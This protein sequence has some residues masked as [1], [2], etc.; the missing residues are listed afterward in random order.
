LRRLLRAFEPGFLPEFY[1][2]ASTGQ[3]TERQWW[4]FP[5]WL[6]FQQGGYLGYG[7]VPAF[8][9][10]SEP[11]EPL[12]LFLP[13]GDYRYFRQQLWFSTDPS[14]ILYLFGQIDGGTYFNGRLL[15]ADIS[16]QCSPSPYFSMVGR[17]N[18][19][20][21]R[22][23]GEPAVDATVDLFSL[24]GRLALN[25]RLQL[26]G[27]YQR[28]TGGDTWNYN[29]RLSWEFAPLSFVYLVY[30]H[31]AYQDDWRLQRREEHAIFKVSYL[32]QL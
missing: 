12:G 3:M 9:R 11:F 6:N 27:F 7:M 4:F 16:L 8:Q 31:N 22:E 15:A 19:N 25:P 14:R 30:N 17:F 24:E 2:Q 10:L 28:N 26:M 32:R 13:A 18:R 5:L 20:R 1:W 21:F 29:V 23:V